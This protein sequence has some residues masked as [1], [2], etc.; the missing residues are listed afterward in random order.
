[1][2]AIG[3]TKRQVCTIVTWEG[4]W[5]FILT[6]GL[7]I[8]VGSAADFMI[9]N[10]VKENLGFGSFHYPA[11]PILLYL[12]LSQLS[13]VAIPRVIYKKVGTNSVVQRLR[14]N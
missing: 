2:E 14:D 3:A 8:T 6:L 13:C 12:M 11:V 1:M 5:Y 7:T 9:F 4:L 10:I